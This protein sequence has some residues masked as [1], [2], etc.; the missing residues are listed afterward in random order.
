MR[1]ARVP[2]WYTGLPAPAGP[3]SCSCW[4][5]FL[6]LPVFLLPVSGPRLWSPSSRLWS[7][8]LIP[9]P[10]PISGYLAQHPISGYLAQHPISLVSV[11]HPISLVPVPHPISGNGQKWQNCSKRSKVAKLPKTVKRGVKPS[12][13]RKRRGVKPREE[14]RRIAQVVYPGGGRGTQEV[15]RVVYPGGVPGAITRRC[16]PP[17]AV[18]PRAA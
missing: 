16:V 2:G 15:F 7:P 9:V 13:D 1:A 17:R 8:S 11:P 6:L 5:S 14:K 4:S 12:I 10:H 3:P 18:W